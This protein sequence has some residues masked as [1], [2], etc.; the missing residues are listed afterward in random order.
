[1]FID[2]DVETEIMSTIADRVELDVIEPCRAFQRFWEHNISQ[3]L[4]ECAAIARWAL[5]ESFEDLV[6][7][8]TM[9]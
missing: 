6:F 2:E 4:F 8:G 7:R 3:T 1:M 9:Q 5:I